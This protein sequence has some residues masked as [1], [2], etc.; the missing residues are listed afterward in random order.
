MGEDKYK[1]E[2]ENGKKDEVGEDNDK[3]DKA[4]DQKAGVDRVYEEKVKK[5]KVLNKEIKH[6]HTHVQKKHMDSEPTQTEY[7]IRIC[8]IKKL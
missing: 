3:E 6:E 5:E 1:A 8:N 7:A 4:G 2:E